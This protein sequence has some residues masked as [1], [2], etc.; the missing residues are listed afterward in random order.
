MINRIANV[1]AAAGTVE[2]IVAGRSIEYA[3]EDSVMTLAAASTAAGAT[4]TV[5]LTDEVVMDESLL[6]VA[7]APAPIMP[8]HVLIARQAVARGDHLIIRVV[9]T[10]ALTVTTLIEVAPI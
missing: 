1:F 5:R 4:M 2:N 8:D 6:P 10:A 3:P 9:A 7:A